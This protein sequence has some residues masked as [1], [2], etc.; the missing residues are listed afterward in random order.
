M[1]EVEYFEQRSSWSNPGPVHPSLACKWTHLHGP[2]WTLH[3][4][5]VLE[6]QLAPRSFFIRPSLFVRGPSS[7]LSWCVLT[8][9]PCLFQLRCISNEV[10]KHAIYKGMYTYIC[11][12]ACAQYRLRIMYITSP[13]SSYAPASHLSPPIE[14]ETVLHD[15]LCG[16]L[17]P[18]GTACPV[19]QQ[20]C[21]A[22]VGLHLA[23]RD[24]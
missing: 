13:E 24:D 15:D 7:S 1:G 18:Y 8:E 3:F 12:C 22:D 10:G 23:G 4:Q 20:R 14:L 11:M 17:M 5:N 16:S 2:I 6:L 21:A 9:R 19:L